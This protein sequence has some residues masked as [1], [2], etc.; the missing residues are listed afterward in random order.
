MLSSM[1][2]IK[3]INFDPF[4]KEVYRVYTCSDNI[5]SPAVGKIITQRYGP[6]VQGA[7]TNIKLIILLGTTKI[8]FW[9]FDLSKL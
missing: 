8:V 6:F 2:D 5:A 3:G 7:S 9:S 1:F 4:D